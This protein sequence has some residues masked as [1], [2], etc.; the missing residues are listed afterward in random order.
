MK[1]LTI[2]ALFLFPSV[3]CAQQRTAAISPESFEKRA[4]FSAAAFDIVWARPRHMIDLD[5]LAGQWI[6]RR[7]PLGNCI[8]SRTRIRERGVHFDVHELFNLQ[9]RGRD[10]DGPNH[11]KV[12]KVAANER[13]AHERQL[14][15]PL[16]NRR[17]ES[18]LRLYGRLFQPGGRE[19]VHPGRFQNLRNDRFGRQSRR[20]FNADSVFLYTL[21]VDDPFKKGY[22]HCTGMIVSKKGRAS[23]GLK[24]W[25]TNAGKKKEQ[26]YLRSLRRKI[27]YRNDDWKYDREVFERAVRN[28]E[29]DR[30]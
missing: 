26:Q 30:K 20:W 23:I 21:P 19:S 24:L 10:R 7:T 9:N 6:R 13:A 28:R 22:T 17:I 4:E 8:C 12:R 14:S 25:F 15:P 18:G 27:R 3:V 11:E 29:G 16:D 1:R 5:T 2:L